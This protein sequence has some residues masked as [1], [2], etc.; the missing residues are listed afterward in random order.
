MK[1]LL[2]PIQI[3]PS[4][5]KGH[6]PRWLQILNP[7]PTNCHIPPFIPVLTRYFQRSAGQLDHPQSE[8]PHFWTLSPASDC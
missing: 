5:S 3:D 1:T 7:L 2:D 4:F 8:K 6:C